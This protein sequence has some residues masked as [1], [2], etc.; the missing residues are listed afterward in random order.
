MP[1]ISSLTGQYAVRLP[2]VY[3]GENWNI[4]KPIKVLFVCC[5]NLNLTQP[6]LNLTKVGFDTIIG[7]HHRPPT[8]Y[9][10]PETLISAWEQFKAMQ[11]PIWASL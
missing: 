9:H 7:L 11:N 1:K 4:Y 5:Q 8:T 10:P 2:N 6:Q 3:T